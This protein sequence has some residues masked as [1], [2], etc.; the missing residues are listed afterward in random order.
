MSLLAGFLGAAISTG[1]SSPSFG[2]GAE[3]GSSING[4][5]ALT[6]ISSGSESFPMIFTVLMGVFLVLLLWVILIIVIGGA[7]TLGYAKYNLNLVDDKDPKV[8]DIF[9]STTVWE[10]VLV[11]SF[12]EDCLHFCGPCFCDSWN[13]CKLPLF[14]DT[15]YSV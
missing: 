5:D 7:T 3:T 4:A 13:H 9:H 10:P 11:C 6:A 12:L 1:S 15:I 8:S 2:S 14:Y